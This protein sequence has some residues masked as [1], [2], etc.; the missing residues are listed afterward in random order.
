MPTWAIIT[1][2]V[3]PVASRESKVS[4]VCLFSKLSTYPLPFASKTSSSEFEPWISGVPKRDLIRSSRRRGSV[5][6]NTTRIHEDSGP[7]PDLAQW[8]NDPALP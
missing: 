5:V 3:I 8:V 7:I 1:V 6:T 2:V 4:L